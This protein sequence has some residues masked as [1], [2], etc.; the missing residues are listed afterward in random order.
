MSLPKVAFLV[1]C[2]QTE[3]SARPLTD[4]LKWLA[5]RLT[6]TEVAK[7]MANQGLWPELALYCVRDDRLP[8]GEGAYALQ[9][10]DA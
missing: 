2:E 10:S 8:V 9:V 3:V 6:G 1:D 4:A 7:A 5:A